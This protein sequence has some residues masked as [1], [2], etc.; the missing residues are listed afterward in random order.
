M[1][2]V[3]SV[4]A[5]ACGLTPNLALM[6]EQMAQEKEKKAL[7]ADRLLTSTTQH[8]E[9]TKQKIA[10]VEAQMQGGGGA[11]DWTKTYEKWDAWED[12]EE[13]ARQ[14]QEARDRS[15][16]AARDQ[17]GCNHDH[18]AVMWMLLWRMLRC[19]SC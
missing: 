19:I 16:R 14:E 10:Q 11:Y 12:P 4:A 7:E 9:R 18:S 6:L 2:Q 5:M 8:V 1:R 15:E 3:H 17:M 13:L